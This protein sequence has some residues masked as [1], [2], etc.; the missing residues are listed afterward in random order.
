MFFRRTHINITM[1]P[2]T[3]YIFSTPKINISVFLF[4]VVVRLCLVF[5]KNMFTGGFVQQT[6]G[7]CERTRPGAG[8][9]LASW[10]EVEEI[11]WQHTRCLLSCPQLSLSPRLCS[12]YSGSL[13]GLRTGSSFWNKK[14]TMSR[15]EWTNDI[16]A[17]FFLICFILF[18]YFLLLWAESLTYHTH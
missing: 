7:V 14:T 2:V 16:F 3:F 1:W 5:K 11:R 17:I 18:I 6:A 15:A 8:H 4:C 13:E 12:H 9:F 10:A